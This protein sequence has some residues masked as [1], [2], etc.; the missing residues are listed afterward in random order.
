MQDQKQIGP[1]IGFKCA[2]VQFAY[3]ARIWKKEWKF[4]GND[5]QACDHHRTLKHQQF[6]SF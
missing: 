2:T 5:S 1:N 6:K 4:Q 3:V